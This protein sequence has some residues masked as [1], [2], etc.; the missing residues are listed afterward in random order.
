[1]CG[2]AGFISKNKDYNAQKIVQ[3]M[4]DRGVHR[5]PDQSGLAT[6]Q[7]TTIGMVRLSIIDTVEH[8]IPYEDS[9]GNFAIVY[10]G[11]IYNHQEIRKNLKYYTFLTNSDTE[12]AMVSFIDKGINAFKEYNG[13]YAFALHDKKKNETYI[14]RDKVGEKPLYYVKTKDFFAFAS[15]IKSLMGLVEPKLND[16]AVSYRAYE[17]TTGKETLFKDIY[18]LEPGEYIHVKNNKATIKS[19]WKIWDHPIDV[20]DNEAKI[21][22]S[23]AEL[24][25]D[26]ILLR[27]QNSAHAFGAFVSGGIDS[28]LVACIAKPDHLY[29]AHYDY[30]DFN[31]L[32]YAKLVAK[33]LKKKLIIV[34][35]TKDDFLR[36]QE[37]IAYHL[38]TPCTWTSFTLWAL[39]ERISQDGLKVMLT[40]DGADEVFGGYHRYHLLHHDEQIHTLEAMKEYSYLINR[41]YGSPVERYTKLVNRSENPYD[42]KVLKFLNESIGFY[43]EKMQK[44]VVHA[45]GLNDFYST[46]QVLLQMSDR[47]SMAFSIE[48]RSPFLDYRLIQFAFS[49][50]SKYKIKN[51][52][53]KWAL[54][55]VARKFIPKEICDRVDKR[56][57]SAPVNKW[58]EWDKNGKYNRSA[59]KNISF[60]NWKKVYGVH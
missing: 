45:M 12:T 43:F 51:G 33:Q 5:G 47:V 50:P 27:T 41:Y 16:K 11:E 55:E 10:N 53:T 29:T 3:E 31:E 23:L 4:L 44:D 19:Y 57:F 56:G 32:D 6:Y 40:G 26:S 18:L 59:Y 9:S 13:M 49:M 46:M 30:S 52:I 35:P 7:D 37:Q 15:E 1:M 14:V 48:N 58:F 8:T 42:T 60:D 21:L 25:E 38:D 17:F 2:I 20:P 39:M 54:K 22:S 36:T 34:E 24:V 28:S